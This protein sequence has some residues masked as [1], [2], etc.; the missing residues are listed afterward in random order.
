M[1][2][3]VRKAENRAALTFKKRPLLPASER[4]QGGSSL[5]AAQGSDTS[6]HQTPSRSHQPIIYAGKVFN[7]FFWLVHAVS[8]SNTGEA[9]VQTSTFHTKKKIE[10]S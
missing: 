2:K 8:I 10:N 3:A 4:V 6:H 5:A 7:T 9:N 1:A